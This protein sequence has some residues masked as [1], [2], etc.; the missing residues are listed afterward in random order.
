[1]KELG[2]DVNW[3]R[4][5]GAT[6]LMLAASKGYHEI[7]AYLL[8][9]GAD[10]QSIAPILGT[11]ADVSNMCG[12]PPEQ[13]AYLEAKTH[14]SNPCCAGAGLKK[15]TGCKQV[16]YCGHQCQLAHWPAHKADCK[17]AAELRSAK[18]K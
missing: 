6:A 4:K 17:A 13:T 1:V 5:N 10:P 7:V 15:C 11:A 3:A 2:A 9:H 16:R 18:G 8:R 12:A 14:C